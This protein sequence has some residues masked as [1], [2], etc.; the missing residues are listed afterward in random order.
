MSIQSFEETIDAALPHM[1]LGY[2]RWQ[3]DLID[4]T[5]E[6]KDTMCYFFLKNMPTWWDDYLPP[7]LLDQHNF[8][9]E[10]YTNSRS[11]QIS[12]TLRESIYLTLE[13]FLREK[14]QDSYARVLEIPTEEPQ[15]WRRGQ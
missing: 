6:D 1:M 7:N 11:E 15:G 14:V 9:D 3:G 13:T 12:C 2:K 10:L 5:D 4:L 8:L